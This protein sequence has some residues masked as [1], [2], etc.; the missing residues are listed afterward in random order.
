MGSKAFE[1]IKAGME[2]AIAHLEGKN[3]GGR[4][5]RVYVPDINVAAIRARL[6]LSQGDFAATFGV[7]AATVRNWEQGRRR[8]EGPARVLLAVINERPKAVKA[9][10]GVGRIGRNAPKRAPGTG[11]SRKKAA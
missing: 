3:T 4:M 1:A 11:R 2:D 6:G 10:L 7:S 9:A 5:H 8:P